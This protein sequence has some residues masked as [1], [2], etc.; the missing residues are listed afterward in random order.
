MWLRWDRLYHLTLEVSKS[1]RPD[2]ECVLFFGHN[3]CSV[4]GPMTNFFIKCQSWDICW[5]DLGGGSSLSARV[6]I[7]KIFFFFYSRLPAAISSP[8]VEILPKNKANIAESQAMPVMP[9]VIFL[10]TSLSIWIP[11]YLNICSWPC[12]TVLEPTSYL[13]P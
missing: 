11:I 3:D 2:S 8:R 6:I 7:Y 10:K 4:D 5:I 9:R 13:F 12:L 1:F